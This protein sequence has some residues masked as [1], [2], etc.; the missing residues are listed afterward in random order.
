MNVRVDVLHPPPLR[1]VHL[2]RRC[3]LLWCLRYF[4]QHHL[5]LFELVRLDVQL[6]H[7]HFVLVL[8]LFL[9]L[10]QRIIVLVNLLN[11][12]LSL[13]LLLI[14]IAI[15]R[16]VTIHLLFV[17][18]LAAAVQHGFDLLLNFSHFILLPD[19]DFFSLLP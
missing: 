4:W 12:H 8:R 18:F 3:R 1:P 2:D 10:L 9:V 14:R 13:L 6:R 15:Q 19:S 16:L 17:H 11:R 7:S 5:L